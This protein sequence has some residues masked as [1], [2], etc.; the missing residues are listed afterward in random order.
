MLV[1]FLANYAE[2]KLVCP[3]INKFGDVG[4]VLYTV[5]IV[6]FYSV[7]QPCVKSMLTNPADLI[8]SDRRFVRY[9]NEGF[10]TSI[11]NYSVLAKKKMEFLLNFYNNIY[12]NFVFETWRQLQQIQMIIILM[13]K[14][15]QRSVNYKYICDNLPIINQ[16]CNQRRQL[17]QQTQEHANIP[18]QQVIEQ[19][20]HPS[21]NPTLH[22]HETTKY[23]YNLGISAQQLTPAQ[24]EEQNN[25]ANLIWL[26]QQR[27]EEEA[28]LRYGHHYEAGG[29]SHFQ[30][31]QQGGGSSSYNVP[32][33]EYQHIWGNTLPQ[34]P[35]QQGGPPQSLFG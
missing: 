22:G 27:Q 6:N 2:Y 23:P 29:S 5:N 26:E 8:D 20:P 13:G 7:D 14:M 35:P 10:R 4:G 9:R 32:H 25:R 11:N 31:P 19:T 30:H 16:L 34:P 17:E 1:S 18:Q 24:L 3:E 21:A 33:F 15:N 28:R 12:G